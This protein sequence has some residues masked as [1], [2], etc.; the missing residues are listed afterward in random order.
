MRM[1]SEAKGGRMNR[2][3]VVTG[4]LA[5]CAL[6]IWAALAFSWAQEATA[7]SFTPPVSESGAPGEGLCTQCHTGGLN[8]VG[9][10]LE[11]QNVPAAYTPGQ[12][13]SI[14]VQLGR[15]GQS[16]WG[17]QLVPLRDSLE[18]KVM[19]GQ[20]TAVSNTTTVSFG[21]VDTGLRA[22]A[23]HFTGG[24]VDGTFAGTAD[25]PVSWTFNWTAPLAGAGTVTFHC[26]G[27]AANGNGEAGAGDVIYTATATSTEAPATD[28]VTTTTWGKIKSLYLTR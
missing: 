5:L 11:I 9:G 10:S 3:W 4:V 8:L 13:Y 12:I 1:R 6:V 16:R 27:N 24:G 20:L 23:S 18:H 17:F 15:A 7:F 26:A 25:G 19:A 2:L 28:A 22:Y 14:T 21:F